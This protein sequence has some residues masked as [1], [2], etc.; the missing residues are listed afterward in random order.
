V[1]PT[2]EKADVSGS[3]DQEKKTCQINVQASISIYAE[4][5]SNLNNDQL[6]AAAAEIKTSVENAW[7]GSF[8]QGGF[9]VT[10]TTSVSVSVASS[11]KDAVASGAGN[12]VAIK[13][14]NAIPGKA[15]SVVYP[16]LSGIGPDRG[17]WNY[18]QIMSP[19]PLRN[20]AGHEFGHLLGVDDREQVGL[21]ALMN[22]KSTGVLDAT[23]S[24]FRW[25]FGPFVSS[26]TRNF[27]PMGSHMAPTMGPQSRQQTLTTPR[28][29]QWWR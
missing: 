13:N 2:G 11:E 22:H 29:F 7:S 21:N 12:V 9:Q 20:E 8:E 6:Q 25:A 5:G 1:D 27:V 16:N 19:M 15:S 14:G 3:C 10:V 18:N 4:G 28:L 23:Q 26:T 17:V 24:D